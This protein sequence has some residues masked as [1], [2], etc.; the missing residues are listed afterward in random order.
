M[1][2]PIP[3]ASSPAACAPSSAAPAAV[4]NLVTLV[5]VALV[6]ALLG[7]CGTFYQDSSPDVV[8]SRDAA[9][10]RALQVPPDLTDVS[11]GEQFVLPGTEGGA[12]S[13]D[14]LLPVFDDVRFVREG[15]AAWLDFA[16]TPEDLWPRLLAFARKEKYRI[17]ATEPT[18]GTLFTQWRPASAVREGSLLGNLIGGESYSRLGFRLERGADDGARLFARRQEA[19]ESVATGGGDIAWPADATED[20]DGTGALLARLLVFLGV[21]EQRARGVLD[22]AQAASVLDGASVSSGPAGSLLVVNRGYEPAF[23]AVGDAL[24]ALELDVTGSDDGVGRIEYVTGGETRVLTLVPVHVGAVRVSLSDA[25][26]RRLASDRERESLEALR[27][28]LL[29]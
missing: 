25:D 27:A 11:D 18:A 26:G 8:Y 14:T 22:A 10:A 4:P 23:R 9:G 17:E 12:T 28:A 5:A 21:T 1:N 3:S 29:A 20:A 6:P 13:R 15:G 7:G 19:S 16:A 2:R 24:A